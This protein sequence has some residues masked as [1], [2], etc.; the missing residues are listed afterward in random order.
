MG[1]GLKE[2]GDF[3]VLA[4]RWNVAPVYDVSQD[5]GMHKNLAGE[6]EARGVLYFRRIMNS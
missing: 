5:P 2:V 3:G 6:Q 4:G 1:D